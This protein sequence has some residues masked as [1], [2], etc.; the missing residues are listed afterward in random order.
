MLKYA[1]GMSDVN[2]K[3]IITLGPYNPKLYITQN[4]VDNQTQANAEQNYAETEM[5]IPN[6]LHSLY[7]ENQC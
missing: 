3:T 2:Q 1:L 7:T 6:Q 4:K 5:F